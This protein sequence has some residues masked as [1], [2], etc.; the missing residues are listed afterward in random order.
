MKL[1]DS[2]SGVVL[3]STP[4]INYIKAHVEQSA[5]PEVA[6][7]YAARL[8]FIEELQQKREAIL[9]E[10]AAKAAEHSAKY[11]LE[12]KVRQEAK[13]RFKGLLA[14]LEITNDTNN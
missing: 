9:A 3:S 6:G 1:P 10:S 11:A 12:A 8:P 14:A 7:L 4:Q 2:K 5:N 13:D